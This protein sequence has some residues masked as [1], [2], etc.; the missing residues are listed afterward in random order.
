MQKAEQLGRY[1]LLDRIAFGGMAEIFRA[2]TFDSEGNA[3]FVAV[4]RVLAHHAEDKNFIR[5]LVDE[6]QIASSLRHPNI[7]KIYEFAIASGE[8]FIAME[9]VDGKDLRSIL[10]R[11]RKQKVHLA[12]EHAAYITAQV[13][14]GLH[15]AHIAT[16]AKGQP[17]QIVHRDVSP[18]NI[19]CSYFG[20]VKLCD[21]GIAK[22]T[23]ST[24]DTRTG[25][26]KGKVKY[27]SPE[28]ALGRKLDSRSDIFSLGSCLYEMLT[29]RPPFT[30]KTEME[31]VIKVR[32]AKYKPIA[33]LAPHVPPVVRD[34]CDR[35][36]VRSRADRFQ[37]AEALATALVQFLRDNVP[38][39]QESYLGQYISSQ[40][41]REIAEE[42]AKLKE[43]RVEDEIRSDVGENLISTF[44]Q[45]SP[46][47]THHEKT[48]GNTPPTP[49]HSSGKSPPP[50]AN[51][52]KQRRGPPYEPLELDEALH[53][54]P[55]L[56]IKR[57]DSS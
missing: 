2:K 50:L 52:P 56:I 55:T 47:P 11:C 37:S 54:A 12:P 23:L 41:T 30:A 22:A 28:Q 33:D 43:Y 13:A 5:M 35:C 3:H 40:F 6:A 20:H 14:T 15:A 45:F 10:R 16:D 17:L 48:P 38:N 36:M 57:G 51:K 29:G 53:A 46:V 21:F 9:H 8:Y 42:K 32:D 34:I 39:Y 25:I 49:S 24:V 18:S 19:L 44:V 31:L 27:M 26:I 4:K 1:H 7:A